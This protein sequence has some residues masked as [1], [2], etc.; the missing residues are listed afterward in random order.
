MPAV[1][2]VSGNFL[3]LQYILI[4]KAEE[5]KLKELFGD[6][7]D[8]YREAVPRFLPRLSPYP[9]RSNIRPD[10]AGA[11]RSE[12]STFIVIAALVLIFVIRANLL[13]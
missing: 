11:L 12:K 6:K 13:K 8:R 10:F 3:S 7:F 4:I 2:I 1:F 5:K 9:Q